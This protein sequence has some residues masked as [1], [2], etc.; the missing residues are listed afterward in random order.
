MFNSFRD[1]SQKPNGFKVFVFFFLILMDQNRKRNESSSIIQV[2]V[3][4]INVCGLIK[5]N[6]IDDPKDI[7]NER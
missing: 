5:V 1:A 3:T 2:M 7:M 4:L 6:Y